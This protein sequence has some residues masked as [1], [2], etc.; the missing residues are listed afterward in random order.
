MSAFTEEATDDEKRNYRLWR[1]SGKYQ[2]FDPM[3]LLLYGL[4]GALVTPE[5]RL[6]QKEADYNDDP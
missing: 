5:A 3:R 6:P 1:I 2:H 4:D